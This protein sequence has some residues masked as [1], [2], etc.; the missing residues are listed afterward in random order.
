MGLRP[1]TKRKKQLK[2]RR[3]VKC[4][5]QLNNQRTRCKRCSGVNTL[6]RT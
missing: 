2:A 6:L 3:C 4:G 1:R 5:G